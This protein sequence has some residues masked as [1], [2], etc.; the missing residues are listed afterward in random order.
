MDAGNQKLNIVFSTDCIKYPLTGIGRYALELA[1]Q[2]EFNKDQVKLTYLNGISIKTKLVVTEES[3][4]AAQSIKQQ[5]KKSKIA[6]E[7]YRL[8]IPYAKSLV[9]RKFSNH[10]FHS[11]NY[12][13]PPKIECSVATIHDLSVFHWPQFHPAGRVK[14]LQKELI[15]TVERANVLITDSHFTK[16]EVVNFFGLEQDKVVVAPLACNA[17]FH[18]RNENEVQF[19]LNKYNLMWKSYFLYTGTIEPRKNILTLLKAYDC[20]SAVEKQNFP[21]VI[22]GFNGWDNED[23]FRL[24]RKG[25]SEGWLK[26]L[27]FVPEND[28]PALYSAANSFV[29][30]SIY[31]GFGLPVLEAM[32]SGTPVICSNVSSLPEVVGDAAL[33]HDPQDVD[34]LSLYLRMMI[35]DIDK[36]QLMIDS[37]LARAKQFT[38]SLCADKTIEAYKQVAE[39][40]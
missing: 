14:L 15:S 32:A 11:P 28:L 19:V 38:W 39:S 3:S 29:F 2:L 9:L 25:Q 20:L 21:L 12:Y 23:L 17:D 26:Y 31:E 7:I 24:F 6:S 4:K 27:G 35:E 22:S 13:L 37:G 1:K 30:P 34:N 18:Q 36:R 5:I 16:D 33:A 40:L 10:I 8:T